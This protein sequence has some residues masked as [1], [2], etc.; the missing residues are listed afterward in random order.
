MVNRAITFCSAV[1]YDSCVA[2]VIRLTDFPV[3]G[4][5]KGDNFCER[6]SNWTRKVGVNRSTMASRRYPMELRKTAC[7]ISYAN[8]PPN[9]RP[10]IDNVAQQSAMAE[11][12]IVGCNPRRRR[13]LADGQLGPFSAASR[14]FVS[15]SSL[16]RR[17]F[18]TPQ[19]TIKTLPHTI[20]TLRPIKRPY[21][22][23]RSRHL[24]TL[25]RHF[26]TISRHFEPIKRP[27]QETLSRRSFKTPASTHYQD[28]ST[29][30]QDTSNL[31]RDLFKRPYQ[32]GRSRRFRLNQD[33]F[34]R[35]AIKTSFQDTLDSINTLYAI[36]R[37]IAF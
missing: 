35:Y 7:M 11:H 33:A 20:K 29:Q 30:Y 18:K 24:N 21:Q 16:S 36:S 31:S 23:G 37:H 19:H 15:R 1:K 32:D 26:H 5:R 17:H 2:F 12:V 9:K 28:T 10:G 8:S 3:T 13:D 25:S 4:C 27:F 34:S 6:E 14:R 22:D